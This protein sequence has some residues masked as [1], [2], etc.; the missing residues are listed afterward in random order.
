MVGLEISGYLD[1]VTAAF[2]TS[3]FSPPWSG[4]LIPL[5]LNCLTLNRIIITA[6]PVKSKEKNAAHTKSS[7]RYNLHFS[8]I[9]D[10]ISL[11]RKRTFTKKGYRSHSSERYTS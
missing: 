7:G 4:H 6:I 8:T 1:L 11:F 3:H 5:R 9:L 2:L 10:S